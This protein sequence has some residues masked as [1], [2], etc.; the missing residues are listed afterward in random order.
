[1]VRLEDCVI[2]ATR[3]CREG[4]GTIEFELPATM[5]L[6]GIKPSIN[7][8]KQGHEQFRNRRG[9]LYVAC[10]S[11]VRY[12]PSKE[13]LIQYHN[14]FEFSSSHGWPQF[15]GRRFIISASQVSTSQNQTFLETDNRTTILA[16]IEDH[17]NLGPFLD[18]FFAWLNQSIQKYGERFYTSGVVRGSF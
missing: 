14:G 12:W 2:R 5:D 7:N 3:M 16:K 4:R 18:S 8:Y 11:V 9:T 6:Y 17:K 15:R 10:D 1:M 13:K